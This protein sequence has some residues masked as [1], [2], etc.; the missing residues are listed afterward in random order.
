MKVFIGGHQ[1]GGDLYKGQPAGKAHHRHRQR[2]RGLQAEQQHRRKGRRR[3]HRSQLVGQ[4][5]RPLCGVIGHH[6]QGQCGSGIGIAHQKRH[7][8]H[9]ASAGPKAQRA[10]PRRHT[11]NMQGHG[12]VLRRCVSAVEGER[13][14]KVVKNIQVI[15]RG[16]SAQRSCA[17][18]EV[19]HQ[20]TTLA[21]CALGTEVEPHAVDRL[22][23][24]YRHRLGQPFPGD[25]NDLTVVIVE[26]GKGLCIADTQL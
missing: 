19:H 6:L 8:V 7:T 5:G 2:Q 20:H 9:R 17:V 10:I 15:P 25:I 1:R 18:V 13:R 21:R 14:K 4:R 23:G 24:G 3:Q 11:I 12:L 22:P 16:L 26:D